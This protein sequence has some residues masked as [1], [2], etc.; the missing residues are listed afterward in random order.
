MEMSRR[1]YAD[2]EVK[3]GAP[4]TLRRPVRPPTRRSI[5]R[6]AHCT[7]ITLSPTHNPSPSASTTASSTTSTTEAD[8]D[9]TDFLCPHC[10]RTSAS[11][12]GLVG[13]LRIHRTGTGEPVPGAPTYSRPSRLHCP[14]YI[15]TFIHRMGLKDNKRVHENLRWTT[16]GCTKPSHPP[17]PASHRTLTSPTASAQMPPPAQVGSVRLY[18]FSVRLPCCMCDQN[19]RRRLRSSAVSRRAAE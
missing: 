8:T 1:P 5:T 6:S 13:R 7:S 10:C 14:H 16:A 4:S 19:L 2:K 18:C 15:L 3:S 17:L 9:T 12:I 11:R